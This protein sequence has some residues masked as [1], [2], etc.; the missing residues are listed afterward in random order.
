AQPA[1]LNPT[2]WN[3]QKSNQVPFF[4]LSHLHHDLA[5]RSGC[6]QAIGLFTFQDLLEGLFDR[7]ERIQGSDFG[8]LRRA[9]GRDLRTRATHAHNGH[10]QCYRDSGYDDDSS[11]LRSPARAKPLTYFTTYDVREPHLPYTN[12]ILN[13]SG[14]SIW[15][16][17]LPIERT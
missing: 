12:I 9:R 17:L 3:L 8:I 1:R 13:F 6:L 16:F 14:Q 15:P 4:A 5:V 7:R 11:H 2:I 10:D